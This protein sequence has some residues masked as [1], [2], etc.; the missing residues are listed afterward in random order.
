MKISAEPTAS[1]LFP[2][3]LL[4]ALSITA[5]VSFHSIFILPSEYASN[6]R[7]LDILFAP[8]RFCVPVLLTISFFL[9]KRNLEHNQEPI[10][11]IVKKRLIRLLIPTAFWFTIAILIKKFLWYTNK[12]QLLISVLQGTIFPGSYYLLILFQLFPILIF[13][14]PWFNQRRNLLIT[15]I[16]QSIAF[17]FIYTALDGS[18][19]NLIPWV[20]GNIHRPLFIYWFIYMAI[21]AYFYQNWSTLVKLSQRI[22]ISFKILLLISISLIMIA[23]SGSL[24]SLNGE[25][26]TPYEYAMFSCIMSVVAL[27]I[28]F[29]SVEENKITLPI[30][31]AVKL[32]SNYSLGIFCINGI[33]NITLVAILAPILKQPN[34]NLLQILGMKLIGWIFLLAL[35][36]WISKRIDKLGFPALVR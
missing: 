2:I 19:G 14:H 17:I 33:V 6:A 10:Y 20:L 1:R 18:F 28:C 25:S 36:I 15:F 21:G 13:L 35:S 24:Q 29:A 32:L 23:E 11:Q 8:F 12:S 4:K 22:P 5:V 34:L 9:L 27:F 30:K 26:I 7:L 31:K 16:F 3:D